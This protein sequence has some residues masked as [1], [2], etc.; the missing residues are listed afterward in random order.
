ME[1]SSPDENGKLLWIPAG[2]AHAF[3]VLGDGLADV[4]YKVDGLYNPTDGGIRWDDP[5][6]KIP[7]PVKNPIVS[8]KDARLPTFA[9]Y[10]RNPPRWS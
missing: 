7:W 5:D 2:F 10:R 6:L 8:E 4:V 9:E 3:C 1:S